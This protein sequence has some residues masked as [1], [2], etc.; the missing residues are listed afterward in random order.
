MKKG[1]SSR[2]RLLRKTEQKEKTNA[3]R[4]VNNKCSARSMGSKAFLNQKKNKSASGKDMRQS[5]RR[6]RQLI[7]F[8]NVYLSQ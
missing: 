3:E 2:E 7:I 8:K 5:G 6:Q 1:F 4:S